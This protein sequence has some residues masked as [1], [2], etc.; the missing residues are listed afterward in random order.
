[1][2]NVHAS[3]KAP[4]LL[5]PIIPVSTEKSTL[6]PTMLA[7]LAIVKE[8]KERNEKNEKKELVNY[9]SVTIIFLD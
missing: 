2:R 6:T 3:A 1:M 7:R 5:K 8:K 9:H 4:F